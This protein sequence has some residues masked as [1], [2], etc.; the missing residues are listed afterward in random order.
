[1]NK[2]NKKKIAWQAGLFILIS[3]Y[4][5]ITSTGNGVSLSNIM[6]FGVHFLPSWTDVQ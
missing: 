1:M 6:Q 4:A 2:I 3:D 5:T